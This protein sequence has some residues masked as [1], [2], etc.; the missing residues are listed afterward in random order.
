MIVLSYKQTAIIT[1]AGHLTL[2]SFIIYRFDECEPEADKALKGRANRLNSIEDGDL[3]N[4]AG[5]DDEEVRYT[6]R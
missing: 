1:T 6:H 4:S 5:M 2:Y 3:P